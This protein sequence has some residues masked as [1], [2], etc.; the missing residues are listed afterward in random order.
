MAED[1]DIRAARVAIGR[2]IAENITVD[3]KLPDRL[4]ALLTELK[5]QDEPPERPDRDK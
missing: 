2:R 4:Q 5:R 1:Q 3:R